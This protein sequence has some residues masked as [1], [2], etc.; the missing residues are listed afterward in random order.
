MTAGKNNAIDLQGLFAS[1]DAMDAER[2]V[3]FIAEDGVFRF[4]NSPPATG[5]DEIRAAVVG[6]FTTV[7]GL[8]HD[9]QRVIDDGAGIACEGE[10]TYTRHDGS[11]ITL[12]FATVFGLDDGLIA[13]YGIY[14]DVAPL[15]A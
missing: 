4:G 6:F 10:V 11:V 7:A 5:H 3:S 1:I 8:R 13:Q 2:F 15:F 12:P 14:I 9:V